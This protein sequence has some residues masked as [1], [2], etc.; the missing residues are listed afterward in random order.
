[1]LINPCQPEEN[2]KMLWPAP[3]G[4]WRTQPLS[5]AYAELLAIGLFRAE[6]SAISSGAGALQ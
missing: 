2:V 3:A 6:G 5:A 4:M 1:M